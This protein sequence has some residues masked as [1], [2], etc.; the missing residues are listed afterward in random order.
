MAKSLV[1]ALLNAAGR[2]R[3]THP[4]PFNAQWNVQG[5]Q[6]YGSGLQDRFTQL[7]AMGGTGTLYAIVQLLS[8][9]V[10][11][12]EWSMYRTDDDGRVR[13]SKSD[14]GSDQ[15]VEVKR[16]L[17][18]NLWNRPNAYMTGDD[19]RE[20]GW[21][22]MEL[23]GEWYWVMN[24]GTSGLAP[25]IEIWPV[26]PDRME[27]VPD[28]D[29]YLK[30]WVYTGP[31]GEQV[32][33]MHS[34]VIQLKYPNP[35]DPYRGMSAVQALLAD[36]DN[37]KYSAEWSRNFF[38]NSAVP[39]GIVQFSKRL[40]D[41]EF[42]EFTDRWREQHQGIARGHR[43]GVL[44]QGALWIPNT[45]TMRDMQF[46][47]LRAMSRDV[48]RE[49][50]RIHQSM[51]GQSTDVNRANAQTAEEVHVAWHEIPR[52]RR[53]RTVLNQ[54]FLPMFGS[55]GVRTEFD[56]KD[57]T[58]TSA[59][60][61]NDELTAKSKAAAVLVQG[62]WD[63][64]DVLE[65]V[66]LPPMRFNTVTL[67]SPAARPAIAPPALG[68]PELETPPEPR[69]DEQQAKIVAAMIREAF[70]RSHHNGH[71]KELV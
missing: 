23:V 22:F 52:L 48:I 58:P 67:P 21:Q 30:G 46:T 64:Q 59:N 34:E 5:G 62:G 24:R 42:T 7:Q 2:Y 39:G 8:T 61:A 3:G 54:V 13:Y 32:P 40:T 50:Y 51:L 10:S 43:V 53:M 68:H 6:V 65:V 55:T 11:G 44:E 36:I 15:R 20:I 56:F 66:G 41:D 28:R 29:E 26:R 17:A 37:V 57:P 69:S 71:V 27:P 63:A 25:P 12:H 9:G 38:L 4:I 35:S 49:A 70:D 45:Y 33:L 1:G 14:M 47:E 16:H 31:N 18:L 60:D 19:F